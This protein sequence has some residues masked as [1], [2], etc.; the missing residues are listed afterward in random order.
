MLTTML[1]VIFFKVVSCQQFQEFK[2]FKHK[3]VNVIPHR[4]TFVLCN[5]ISCDILINSLGLK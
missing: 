4:L 3:L 1:K 5:F 2:L